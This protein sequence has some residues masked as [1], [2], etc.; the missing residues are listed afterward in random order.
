[1][2]VEARHVAEKEKL[3]GEVDKL[4]K[5]REDND[6]AAKKECDAAV[7]KV[8]KKCAG[9]VEAMKRKHTDEKEMLEKRIRVLTLTRDAFIVFCFQTGRDLWDLQNDNEDLEVVND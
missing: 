3:T 6:V 7:T 2:D 5:A 8:S 4:K 9:E 1:S